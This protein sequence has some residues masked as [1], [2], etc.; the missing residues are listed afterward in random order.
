MRRQREPENTTPNGRAVL[1]DAPDPVKVRSVLTRAGHPAGGRDRLGWKVSKPRDVAYL[2]VTDTGENRQALAQYKIT[3]N[4]AGY[5]AEDDLHNPGGL[6]VFAA[7][8]R[9]PQVGPARPRRC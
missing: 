8:P 7:D 2:Q 9:F 6:V 1:A 4:Q 5:A 3:L